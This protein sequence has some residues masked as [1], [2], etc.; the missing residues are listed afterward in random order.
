MA[1]ITFLI[2]NW[3]D[4]QCI[5]NEKFSIIYKQNYEWE[6][7]Q[8]LRHLEHYYQ[9][10]VDLTGNRTRNLP[11]VIEDIGTMSNGL[12]NPLFYNIHIF[13]YPPGFG[14]YLEGIEDWYRTVAV[15]EYTHIGHMTKT[16]GIPRIL[17]S[18]LGGLFQPNMYSPG[19]T[20]EGITVYSESR[21]SPYEGR[22][23]DGFFDSY[24]GT[25]V[26]EKRFPSVVEATNSPLSFPYGTIYLYGGEF[27][28]FLST[29]YG[30]EKFRRFYSVYGSYFWA[31]ISAIFPCLGLDIAAKRVYGK[32]FPGLFSEWRRY[33]EN[34]FANWLMEGEQVTN[35]GWYISSLVSYNRKLYLVREMPI[36]V[37]ALNYKNLIQIVEFDID[38][39]KEGVITTLHSSVTTPLR[40]HNE[41]LYYT[42]MELKRAPNVSLGGFGATSVL[43]KRNL[44]NGHEEILFKDDVRS[45]CILNDGTILYTKDRLHQFGSEIWRYNKDTRE[46]ISEVFYLINEMEADSNHIIVVARQNYE[47]WN[48]YLFSNQLIPIA[49]T[50]WIEGSINL[51]KE[52]LLFTANYD[53]IYANYCLDL[54]ENVFYRLTQNGYANFPEIID[55]TLYFIG[56]SKDGF[57]IYK[58]YAELEVYGLNLTQ[59][60]PTLDSQTVK[61]TRGG[62]ENVLK[63]LFPAI[64]LPVIYPADTTFKNWIYGVTFLGGD[65]TNENIY[66]IIFTYNQLKDEPLFDATLFSNLFTPL[67]LELQYSYNN[68][69]NCNLEYPFIYRLSSGPTLFSL[70]M[71]GR[72]F[73]QFKRKEI[74]PGAQI[75]FDYPFTE[76]NISFVSPV[77]MK[78]WTSE[79]DRTAQIFH[80]HLNHLSFGGQLSLEVFGYLDPQNPD[81]PSIYIRGYDVMSSP[82]G[83]ITTI[84]YSHVLVK[85]RHGFWNPNIYFEDLF[86][87][88][89]FDM[90]I[91][92]NDKLYYSIGLEARLETKMG[93]GFLQFAPSC[94][95]A[96]T[97]EKRLKFFWRISLDNLK[98]SDKM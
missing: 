85:L 19:W 73:K 70:L 25:R 60:V 36:K 75:V 23:N 22:L 78:I 89:F 83:T 90:A 86:S 71:R 31:P 18:I 9:N 53:K 30:E 44:I 11:I 37:S 82:K 15:H 62:Y 32:T 26:F 16:C 76:L 50:P 13:T 41:N 79:I 40:I 59:P 55:D 7:Q 58:K 95:I 67:G 69:L 48:I 20:I 54:S 10:I 68:Y 12:A 38:T 80:A 2:F 39:K 65:A 1:I 51:K 97:K 74:S 47:N 91:P 43:H 46:K 27:S 88:I 35:K 29:R 84:E 98:V 34:R 92:D 52:V 94:G 64:R 72:A 63:T 45:F 66:N 17:T 87:T 96:F 5:K 77:E 61:F 6:A 28:N 42:T 3:F 24:I 21:I 33:E 8:T 81:T 49:N 4:W 57:D 14:S 56:L 93:F